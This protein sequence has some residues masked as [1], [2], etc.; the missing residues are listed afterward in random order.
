MDSLR[1]I[2]EYME[3][4]VDAIQSGVEKFSDMLPL[5]VNSQIQKEA[6]KKLDTTKSNYLNSLNIKVENSVLIVEIDKDNWLA[7]AVESGISPFNMK[8][9]HLKSP[10]AKI[11]KSGYRYMR[12]PIGKKESPVKDHLSEISQEYQRRINEVLSNKPKFSL[13]KTTVKP[14]GQVYE[15]QKLMTTDPML[16]GFYR[17][18]V[19]ESVEAVYSGKSKPKWEFVMFRT[20]SENPLSR[21]KWDHPGIQ[22]NYILKSTER[23]LIN[24]ID[25]IVDEFIK[26]E[27]D[28]M[29]VRISN[30][31]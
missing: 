24:S 27:I 28:A 6:N 30:D 7:N 19:H 9:G 26:A 17:T 4:Y 31:F 3:N 8:D 10:K 29:H 20:M 18:R 25:D 5:L 14:T 21:S 1:K 22:G 12:I 11:G 13:S 16:Q 23:W 15:S 2:I